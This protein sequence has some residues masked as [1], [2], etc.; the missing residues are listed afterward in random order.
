M[1]ELSGKQ[2][3]LE[4]DIF[5]DILDEATLQYES[6]YGQDYDMDSFINKRTDDNWYDGEQ[7]FYMVIENIIKKMEMLKID[8]IYKKEEI[9]KSHEIKFRSYEKTRYKYYFLIPN[10]KLNFSFSHLSYEERVFCSLEIIF[11]LLMNKIKLDLNAISK[12]FGTS[13]SR[14]TYREMR[15]IISESL[16][17]KIIK[18]K[19]NGYY[20][21]V[22]KELNS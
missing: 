5:C 14:E 1:Y 6:E 2:K 15:L 13:V 16:N 9:K 7:K 10:K 22:L 8:F 19:K 12:I 20:D 21:I 17:C 4:F 3:R 11:L 18:G